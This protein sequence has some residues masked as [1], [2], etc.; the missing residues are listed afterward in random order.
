MKKSLL[1]VVIFIF[2]HCVAL[3]GMKHGAVISKGFVW[4][5]P[6]KKPQSRRKHK[7]PMSTKVRLLSQAQGLKGDGLRNFFIKHVLPK[8]PK[9]FQEDVQKRGGL[10]EIF[11]SLQGRMR[12][13]QRIA[14]L[15]KQLK[16]ESS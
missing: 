5:G 9:T 12:G 6:F 14:K 8:Y 3:H 16:N 2:V 13:K 1:F 11:K 7:N 15:N 10:F 4:D